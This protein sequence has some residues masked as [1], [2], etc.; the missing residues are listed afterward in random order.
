VTP[1]TRGVADA[2]ENGL[3]RFLGGAQRLFAPGPPVDRIFG[4]L[5]KIRV[6]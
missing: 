5:Q 1:V 6:M 3:V 2:E 4:M